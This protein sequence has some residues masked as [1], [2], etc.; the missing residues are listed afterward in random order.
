MTIPTVNFNCPH[1]LIPRCLLPFSLQLAVS[2]FTAF[3]TSD[4]G[5]HQR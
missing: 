5:N 3:V 4:Y 1:L 2:W